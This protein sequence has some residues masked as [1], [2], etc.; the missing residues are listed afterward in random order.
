[1]I[2][3][4]ELRRCPQGMFVILRLVRVHLG[5]SGFKLMSPMDPVFLFLGDVLNGSSSRDVLFLI[6][7]CSSSFWRIVFT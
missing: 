4:F 5:E 3:F 1:M 6:E 2:S 7:T